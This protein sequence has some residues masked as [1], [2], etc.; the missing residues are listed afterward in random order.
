ML[1][2]LAVA[3][4]AATPR[5]SEVVPTGAI[6]IDPSVTY[7][8]IEHFGASGAW[9]A[10]HV[11]GWEDEARNRVVKLLFDAEEGAGLSIFRYN[12]GGG[13]G[14]HI[15]DPWRRAE[16]FEVA[17]GEY[18]WTRDANAVWVLKAARAAGVEHFVAFAN[19]P[20]ARMTESGKT[21]GADYG[22]SNLRTDM[23]D[24]FARYLVDVTRHLREVEGVPV[25][26]ISPINEPL[27]EWEGS[28]QEGCHYTA[29]ECIAVTK[30]LLRAIDEAGIDVVADVVEAPLWRGAGM[31]YVAP[32]FGDEELRAALGHFSIHS[33]WSTR[34]Q[35]AA[36]AALIRE[37]FPRLRLWMSEWTE[38][39]GGRDYGMDSALAMANVMHDD[40]TVASV[41]SWQYW[42]AVSRYD[43][44]DGLIYVDEDTH[45]VH[46]TKRL[47]TMAAYSR[48]V[49]PGYVRVE[50]ASDHPD[51]RVT[52]FVSPDAA[53]TVVVAINAGAEAVSVAPPTPDGANLLAVYETSAAHDLAQVHEGESPTT[54]LLPPESVSTLV[55][56]AP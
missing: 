47:R 38:M 48:F 3:L 52:A 11:G 34:E 45:A 10:Q 51:L 20:P 30:A 24:Q 29:K 39:K 15:G 18:D 56:R 36:E 42:I 22:R 35:K 5:A 54:L 14:E 12:I 26:Y 17:E 2:L 6:T 9:W 31:L 19:S 49:R 41:T 23:H 16:T 21:S 33:Y 55:F 8:T 46:E 50:A 53:E 25:R 44:R 43:F 4:F 13:D 32:M 27:W 7:Q 1:P 40:L 37:R 28:G